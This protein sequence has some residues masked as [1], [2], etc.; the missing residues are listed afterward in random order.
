MDNVTFIK[1]FWPYGAGVVGGGFAWLK[2][3]QQRVADRIKAADE[4]RTAHDLA[5]AKIAATQNDGI[6]LAQA[7]ATDTMK[8]QQD[9]LK[10]ARQQYA[11]G[12]QLELQLRRDLDGKENELRMQVRLNADL[13]CRI[14][15]LEAQLT[16]MD[17]DHQK[18][19]DALQD[20]ILQLEGLVKEAQQVAL[21]AKET[22]RRRT[23]AKPEADERAGD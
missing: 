9:E 16:R 11:H 2:Y 7:I 20:R 18:A 1:T 3:Q 14:E 17:A 13:Q 5:D 6:R 8:R 21:S 10:E 15:S 23:K 12:L 19:R 22:L 4:I